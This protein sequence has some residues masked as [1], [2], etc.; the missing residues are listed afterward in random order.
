MTEKQKIFVR[1]YLKDFN[2][3][4]AYKVAYPSCKKDEAARVN[5]SKLLTKTNI[6]EAIQK[7]ADKRLEKVE[8]SIDD[9]LN[10]LKSIAFSDRTKISKLTKEEIK[11]EI[12]GET[13]ERKY[14]EFTPTNEIDSDTKKAI[15]GYK[16]TQSGMSVETYDKMKALELLGKYLGIFKENVDVN[17]TANKKF[18]EICDQIGGDGLD[19]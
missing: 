3:T 17:V 16:V 8:I 14:V 2:G 4:R 6:K 5:A 13:L 19:E 11:D 1:E 9:V 7:Q 10:E 12:T 15:A 18:D